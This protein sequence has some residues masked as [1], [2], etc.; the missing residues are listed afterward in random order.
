MAL[1]RY[2]NGGYFQGWTAHFQGN[3]SGL[4]PNAS[5]GAPRSDLIRAKLRYGDETGET[6]E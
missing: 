5:D 3:E 1:G 2:P 4:P 6:N